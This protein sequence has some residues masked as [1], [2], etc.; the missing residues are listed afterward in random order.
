MAQTG[1]GVLLRSLRDGRGLSL[2]EVGQLSEVDH[3]YVHRL[4]TGDKDSPSVELLNKLLRVLKPDERETEMA[5]WLAGH[6][7]NPE[8]VDY[9][10]KDKD[11]TAEMFITAAGMKHRGNA[12]PD[13]ETTVARIKKLFAE[14]P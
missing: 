11:F 6:E 14:E 5:K 3:A 12:R 13:I 2:R 4:E 1:L 7:A 10:L 8:L 9:T